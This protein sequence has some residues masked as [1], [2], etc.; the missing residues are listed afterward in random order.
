MSKAL[1]TRADFVTSILFLVL[2]VY[3]AYEGWGMPEAGPI[4]EPGGE[5]GRVPVM[6][7][8]FITLCASAL[9]VRSV[10]R[11]GHRSTSAENLNSSGDDDR[12]Q[13]RLKCI[14]TALGCS[15]YAVG[16]IGSSWFG[17]PVP[18]HVATVAF[19]FIFIVGFEWELAPELGSKRWAWL[20]G[21]AP[22][23][24]KFLATILS[25]VST[26]RAPYLWLIATAL[27]QALLVTW[28]VTHL[29]EQEFYVTLP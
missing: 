15:F 26:S 2:G 21:K 25:F 7:G 6:L 20:T 11:G 17:L 5:P 29:F 8:V 12:T 16:L 9:L 22:G 14:L 1:M 3:L 28:A 19:I 18:Y 13:R 24:A 23:L 27:I 4:I 10:G